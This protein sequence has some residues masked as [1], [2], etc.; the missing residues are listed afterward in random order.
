MSESKNAK[1]KADHVRRCAV[2]YVRQSSTRQVKIYQES[3][4]VQVGLREKA[5][6][7]GWKN[8]IVICMNQQIKSNNSTNKLIANYQ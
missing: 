3:A 4:R 5:I 7:L 2:V 8:P 1:I 6:Q